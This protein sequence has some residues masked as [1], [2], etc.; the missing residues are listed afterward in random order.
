[1]DKPIRQY[2]V[3]FAEYLYLEMGLQPE[4]LIAS[5][6][7]PQ[8]AVKDLFYKFGYKIYIRRVHSYTPVFHS[9][10]IMTE[11]ICKDTKRGTEYSYCAYYEIRRLIKIPTSLTQNK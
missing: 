10:D 6:T 5:G 3:Q 1:M 9:A 7:D 4:T 8:K 11:L 2:K